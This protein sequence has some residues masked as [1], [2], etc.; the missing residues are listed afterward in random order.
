MTIAPV[1]A[2]SRCV[3][4]MKTNGG[5]KLSCTSYVIVQ[6][7]SSSL[8]RWLKQKTKATVRENEKKNQ[9]EESKFSNGL[10]Q[11]VLSPSPSLSQVTLW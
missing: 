5:K 3:Y 8:V 4:Q 10:V 6:T 9:E 7:W 2:D 1:Q 11:R